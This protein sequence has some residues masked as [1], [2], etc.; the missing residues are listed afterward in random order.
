V[1]KEITVKQPQREILF[2][3]L[4]QEEILRLPVEMLEQLVASGEPI[5]FRAGSAQVLGSFKTQT[6]RLVIELAQIE[7]GG[8]GVLPALASLARQYAKAHGLAAVEWIVHAVSCAHPNFKLRSV[9]E[10][11]GFAVKLIDGI[12]EAYYSLDELEDDTRL[13]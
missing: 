5:V 3:G 12:G 2:E 4:C 6:H 9:L 7:G 8:E 13:L 1:E 10:H 11:R